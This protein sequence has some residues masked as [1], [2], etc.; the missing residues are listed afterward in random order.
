MA[1][2]AGIGFLLVIPGFL[3]VVGGVLIFI[4]PR[5]LVWLVGS[6]AILIGLVMLLF[7]IFIRKMTHA[8]G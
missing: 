5:V 6:T 3:L 8:G 7:A 1:E 2:N 4:E